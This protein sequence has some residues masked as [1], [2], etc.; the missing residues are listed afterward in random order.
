MKRIVATAVALL[1]LCSLCLT[2]LA[3]DPHAS[4][5][6]AVSEKYT[7]DGVVSGVTA[8]VNTITFNP[9]GD[10]SLVPFA[11]TGNTGSVCL[12]K[13][14]VLAA[15]AAGYEVVGAI[16][17]SFFDMSN[18]APCGT[19]ISNG[20]LIFTHNERS[21]SVATFDADGK[22]NVVT[23]KITFGFKLNG[24]SYDGAIGL[25]NKVYGATSMAQKNI[26]G[27]F[28]YYDIDA[29]DLADEDVTGLE[30][31]CEITGG[32]QIAVG[33]TING[34]VK[35]VKKESYYGATKVTSANQFVLFVATNGLYFNRASIMK[36]GDTV[37]ITVNESNAAAA[38]YMKN[39]VSAISSVYWLVKDG[40]DITDTTAT[41]IH[42]TSL[43]RAWT[44][45]GIKEDGS[46]VFFVSEEYGLTLK[47]VA[48]E[49]IR[50]GCKNVVRLDGG[51]S[52]S[53]Y[54]KG[55]DFVM[56]SSRKVCDVLLIVA[57][58]SI[59]DNA[60]ET[61]DVPDVSEPESSVPESSA[62]NSEL[63]SDEPVSDENSSDSS[64]YEPIGSVD[65]ED[66]DLSDEGD[67]SSDGEDEDESNGWIVWVIIGVVIIVG[68]AACFVIIKK[69]PKTK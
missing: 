49:M 47:D 25:V 19:L 22:M 50:L 63:T 52:T 24:Q 54:V 21:E 2:V 33:N 7:V 34:V 9:A 26:K 1:M 11:Y 68:G 48:D 28:Q 13:D 66:A 15:E 29:G 40:V 36:A 62:D 67:A 37:D 16:N 56:N 46:Y 5:Y 12:A 51:G 55:E 53:M 8:Q 4:D 69:K 17:G 31:L 65:P 18:G 61:P 60:P 32:G 20:K 3:R 59:K 10:V 23:S 44:A 30:I 42:S 14:H 38:E 45:F 6:G 41:I 57:K 43:A 27:H 39:A 58:N 64:F 35:E